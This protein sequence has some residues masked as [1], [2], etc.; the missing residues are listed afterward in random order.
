MNSLA[1]SISRR[2]ASFWRSPEVPRHGRS[3]RCT[4]GRP[5]FF[6]NSQCLACGAQLGYEPIRGQVC[7]LVPAGDAETWKVA[8]NAEDAAAYRRCA[9]F[10][11]PAS[12]NWLVPADDPL[13]QCRSCRLN[14]Q[15]AD[16]SDPDNQRYWLAIEN[17]KR[18]LV[19]QL[20]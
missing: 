1:E 15:I 8:G 16:L 20:L 7:A 17:A 2:L 13:R 6:R 4:C 12:C 3:Y 14:R 19:S 11:S 10:A 5:I 9:N 18:R